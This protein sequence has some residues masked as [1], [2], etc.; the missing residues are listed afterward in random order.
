M[1]TP[2]DNNRLCHNHAIQLGASRNEPSKPEGL[3][4]RN[5][6]LKKAG[7]FAMLIPTIFKHNVRFIAQGLLGYHKGEPRKFSD[8]ER[9]AHGVGEL[10]GR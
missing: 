2:F 3:S 4:G 8:W 9:F 6:M 1:A 10:V 7:V 5:K